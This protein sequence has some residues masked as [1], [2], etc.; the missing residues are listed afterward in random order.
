MLQALLEH[1]EVV[2]LLQYC[3]FITKIPIA[4]ST[5]DPFNCENRRDGYYRS[6]VDCSVY[7]RCLGEEVHANVCEL[8]Q[9]FS[10]SAGKC[11]A[12]SEVPGCGPPEDASWYNCLSSS[13]LLLSVI[14]IFDDFG[15]IRIYRK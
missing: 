10:F 3:V 9:A 12:Y 11:I 6:A 13:S 4:V 1:R 7:Y 14:S 15:I 2:K 5:P 8:D